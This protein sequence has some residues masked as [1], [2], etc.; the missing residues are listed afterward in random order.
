MTERRTRTKTPCTSIT[1]AKRQKC[2]VVS[3][4][5]PAMMIGREVPIL[6]SYLSSKIQ[7]MYICFDYDGRQKGYRTQEHMMKHQDRKIAI[8]RRASS[9]GMS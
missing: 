5:S 1:L 4:L 3:L 8:H 6:E 2:V 7:S 9:Q